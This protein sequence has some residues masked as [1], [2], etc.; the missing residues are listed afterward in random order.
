[1]TSFGTNEA[2]DSRACGHR[3]TSLAGTISES[4]KKSLFA[5]ILSIRLVCYSVQPD[6][7]AELCAT[8]HQTAWEWRHRVMEAIDGYQDRI[9]P[10]DEVWMDEMHVTDSDLKGDPGWEPKRGLSKDKICIAVAIDVHKNVFVVRCGHGKPSARRIKDALRAHIAEGSEIFHDMEKSHESLA[11]AVKGVDRPYKADTKDQEYL[12]KMAMVNNACSARA[13]RQHVWL[14]APAR[15]GCQLLFGRKNAP[16]CA[17]IEERAGL[18]AS[19]FAILRS[20]NDDKHNHDLNS[21]GVAAVKKPSFFCVRNIVAFVACALL[22]GLCIHQAAVPSPE[23][24]SYPQWLINLGYL[25][26]LVPAFIGG[27]WVALDK[28]ALARRFPALDTITTMRWFTVY[29]AFLIVLFIVSGIAYFV[30]TAA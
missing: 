25:G 26:I 3:F 24:A 17:P 5:W 28:R 11:R 22:V 9:V 16:A 12:E 14:Q 10:R 7:A 1:M 29:A 2:F 13:R 4:S 19:L 27:L 23:T 30:G 8:S 6:A 20:M 18:S 15:F 21:S